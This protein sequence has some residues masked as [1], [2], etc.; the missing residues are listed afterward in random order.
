MSQRFLLP[1]AF[2]AIGAY[3]LYSR[4]LVG[5][6]LSGE[7]WGD[8]AARASAARIVRAAFAGEPAPEARSFP[9]QR[10]S[11]V[12]LTAHGA[13]W[14]HRTTAA[15]ATTA[16]S[17]E[18]A[19]RSLAGGVRRAV[20]AGKPAPR[21]IVV[22]AIASE[23]RLRATPD[24]ATLERLY[25]TGIDGLR[26]ESGGA[27]GIVAP[28][29]PVTEGWFSPRVEDRNKETKRFT[30]WPTRGDEGSEAR[31]RALA[32]L[33][34]A[35]G[36][37]LDAKTV[38]W[39][40]FRTDSFL[41]DL[42]SGD[43]PPTALFRG[44]PVGELRPSPE[45]IRAAAIEGGEWLVSMLDT[46]GKFQYT[47]VPN[48]DQDTPP[49][50]YSYI[51]HTATAW[52]M[53]KLGKRFGREDWV[54]AARRALR[55]SES[56]LVPAMPAHAGRA[57]RGMPRWIVASPN[58]AKG[59]L[60]HNAVTV[61]AFAEMRDE[62]TPEQIAKVKGLGV[63]LEMMLRCKGASADDPCI[64][65]GYEADE[66]FNGGF[67]ESE[68]ENMARPPKKR[69]RLPYEP[70]EGFLAL[71]TLA[72]WF[73]EET[74]WR[75]AAIV[76]ASYQVKK[77]FMDAGAD[78]FDRKLSSIERQRSVDKA[79]WLTMGLEKLHLVT[80]D[81]YWAEACAELGDAVLASG[82]PPITHSLTEDARVIGGVP[83][84][85]AG[86]FPL[87]GRPPRTTPTGSR[88]EGINVARRCAKSIGRDTRP[89]ES[90]L[91]LTAGFQLR[92]QYTE[93]S[94]YFCPRPEKA[95]GAF[96]AG[97]TDN[98]IRIDFIQHVV[99]GQAD[100]LEWYETEPAGQP[101]S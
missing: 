63:S 49:G 7:Y 66:G 41:I 51:R 92:N 65:A 19:A 87:A 98:E 40:R 17:L 32:R 64:G 74:H 37:K 36:T 47:Y 61:V 88:A 1:G 67:F 39:T 20:E 22:D 54:D 3:L 71:A 62:L 58:E 43:E 46:N 34:L 28:A 14:S 2:F 25:E 21:W 30:R 96:R 69:D 76:A 101:G 97:L 35:A 6:P 82:S 75:D 27:A 85:Y 60:G 53:Y 91:M 59:G 12:I 99:A 55:W 78:W 90:M 83:W 4:V 68:M 15:E 5:V 100:T 42:S 94:C 56:T 24:H 84:D 23:Q 57:P 31:N 50:S 95:L 70:G 48:R 73:P 16:A 93:T 86:G 77:R 8:D 80:K 11:G 81:D 18:A 29:D 38:R 89:Y 79:H 26:A 44:M 45:A 9:S 72:E 10:T 33:Q 52:M 13:G